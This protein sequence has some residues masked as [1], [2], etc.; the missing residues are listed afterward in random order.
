MFY[1][2]TSK[3]EHNALYLIVLILNNTASWQHLIIQFHT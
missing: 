3:N 1:D 2:C